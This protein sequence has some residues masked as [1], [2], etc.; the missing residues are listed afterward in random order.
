M[1]TSLLQ[2]VIEAG[3]DFE[4]YPTTDKMIAAVARRLPTNF[5]SLM[6]IGAGDGR[7]LVA[8]AKKAED[9]K[10]ELYAI[11]KSSLLMQAQPERVTPVGVDFHEQNLACLPVDYIFSNP[12]YSEFEVW[13][14]RIIET[15]FA[16]KAFLV[17]PR[18]WKESPEIAAALKKRDATA[19]VIHSDDFEHAERRARAVVDIVEVTFPKKGGYRDEVIDPFDQWFDQNIST[20]EQEQPADD[21]AGS[22][23]LARVRGL[24]SIPE[25]VEA[26][27]EDYAR[28]EDNYRAIFKL[29]YALLRE[30]GVSKDAVREGIK[31]RMAG[32]KS[33]YWG[34]LFER[35]DMITSRLSTAT[36]RGFL[37]RLTGRTAVAF[38]CD[39]AYAIV[40]WAI[41]H[42]NRYYD[43][44][45]VALFKEL[46]TFEGVQNYKS[47]QRT[48]QKSGWR[49]NGEPDPNSH[50][51]LDYRVVIERHGAIFKTDKNG[52]SF[53]A[54]DYPGN[55]HK[56]SHE[57]IDDIIT[58]LGNLGFAQES[59]SWPSRNR[60]WRSGVWQDFNGADGNVLFQ[61]KA[62]IN[63]NVHLRFKPEA[64]RA[65]NVEAGRL[66]G[67]LHSSDDVERVRAPCEP[68]LSH[69][70]NLLHAR[71]IPTIDPR[72]D[73]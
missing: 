59:P 17:M 47:N 61:A 64:I 43:Q 34:L 41:R 7:V 58:V 45:L 32:L 14:T 48:W 57:L 1:A 53:G 35:L 52:F 69:Q 30:L 20:F 28:M 67:W 33:L 10:P 31:K 3:Q 54:Y 29:D 24:K 16:L 62:F 19:R 42:A 2:S 5:S 63:G 27:N 13:A 9:R 70:G 12:P 71:K 44:Q 56:R 4:W 6:D 49:Y 72:R 40:L 55:L 8:L 15:G 50:F 22:V 26:F 46:A 21:D 65:L 39:N 25:L 36:K 68:Q 60:T 18:R 11:E 38:T 66:L 73:G 51:A 23:D 37:E